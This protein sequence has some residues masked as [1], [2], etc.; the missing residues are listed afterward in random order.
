L[1]KT[2]YADE[3]KEASKEED[4]IP[5]SHLPLKLSGNISG[6]RN[7]SKFQFSNGTVKFCNI[8]AG[9]EK[10]NVIFYSERYENDYLIVFSY[11]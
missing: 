7:S 9:V 1:G 10:L 3:N 5:H 4:M 2:G 11:R 8:F 6:I